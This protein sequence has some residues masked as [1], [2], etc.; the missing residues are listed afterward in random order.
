MRVDAYSAIS[1]LYQ[2]NSISSAKKA[3]STQKSSDKLE[4]SQTAKTY[5]VAKAAVKESSDVRIDK[6]EAIRTQM[7]AGTYN[8]SSEAIADKII[9]SMGTIAF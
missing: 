8:I 2:A 6:V 1:Q 9:G 4:F 7:L 5:Q 3:E